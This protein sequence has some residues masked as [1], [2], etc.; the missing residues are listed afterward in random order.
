MTS[1]WCRT[2]KKILKF[3]FQTFLSKCI[4][5]VL[6]WF[7]YLDILRQ[8]TIYDYSWFDFIYYVSKYIKLYKIDM[9]GNLS[10]QW[11]RITLVQG[12]CLF[13]PR[14]FLYTK[15]AC[16]TL[17]WLRI[18]PSYWPTENKVFNLRKRCLVMWFHFMLNE[19][20]SLVLQHP[21]VRKTKRK[22]LLC[23]AILRFKLIMMQADF[24]KLYVAWI[25]NRN[26]LRW[27]SLTSTYS[28]NVSQ[29]NHWCICSRIRWSD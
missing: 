6:S 4:C 19:N 20:V 13:L 12:M 1:R 24:M 5:F 2:A 27:I 3:T 10:L 8:I 9:I 11:L 17:L 28:R 25:E 23:T 26:C 18:F 21:T 16:F 14:D 22:K 15:R 29:Q 7:A